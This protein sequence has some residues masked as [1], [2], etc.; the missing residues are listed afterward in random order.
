MTP[1]GGTRPGSGRPKGRT[2][3]TKSITLSKELWAFVTR[4]DARASAVIERLVKQE[5]D[6]ENSLP[7]L[8]KGTTCKHCGR[9]N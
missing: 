8:D 4:D 6:Y 9:R 3:A 7:R 5:I 2:V 1:R